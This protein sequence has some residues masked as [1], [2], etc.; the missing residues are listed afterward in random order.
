[1]CLLD[2]LFNRGWSGRDTLLV[3]KNDMDDDG[4]NEEEEDENKQLFTVEDIE[5]C[6]REKS[7][8]LN[9]RQN[10]T[11]TGLEKGSMTITPFSAGHTLG[12]LTFYSK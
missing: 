11:I 9:Y 2:A 8:P 12:M 1:M 10:L 3:K 4:I 5:Y 7:I 6:F